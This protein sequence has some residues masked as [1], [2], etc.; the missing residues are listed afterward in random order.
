MSLKCCFT[1]CSWSTVFTFSKMSFDFSIMLQVY[2][3][4]LFFRLRFFSG[5]MAN[6]RKHAN[7]QLLENRGGTV[8]VFKVS[9]LRELKANPSCTRI[10]PSEGSKAKQKPQHM[11]KV[12]PLQPWKPMCACHGCSQQLHRQLLIHSRTEA[13]LWAGPALWRGCSWVW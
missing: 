10:P 7:L 1:S 11:K 12:S 13:W 4:I 9:F 8:C 5:L 6:E 2:P 3:L